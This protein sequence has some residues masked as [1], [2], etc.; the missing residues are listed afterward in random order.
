[1]KHVSGKLKQCGAVMVTDLKGDI[2]AANKDYRKIKRFSTI[3]WKES[4]HYDPLV[5][6]RK[7]SVNDRAIFLENLAITIIPDDGSADSKYFTDGARDFFTG[8]CLY[9][10]NQNINI[11]FP[12]IIQQIVIGNYSKWV[13]EIEVL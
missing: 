8:I 13:I 11:S 10:M 5:N 7:M 3:N 6:A 9:L 2:Y 12:E 1:M 4:A